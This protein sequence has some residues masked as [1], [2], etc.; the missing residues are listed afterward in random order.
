MIW[1]KPKQPA[2]PQ[3]D[4]T[5][6]PKK[7]GAAAFA[8]KNW[9]WLVPV[10]IVVLA[11]GWWLLKPKNTKPANVDTSY[12]EAMPETRDVSNTLSGTGTL[13]PANTYSVKSLVAGKVLTGS[14]EEGDIVEEGTVLYTVD[15]SDATTKVEQAAITL[16]QAQRSYDKTADRQYVRAEVAGVVSS[17]KVNKGDEVKGRP[18]R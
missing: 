12:T 5:A 9:K 11:G 15:S 6:A 8:K 3:Q 18:P 7:G 2:D 1:N 17:L 4:A 16:Q 10:A 14:F 13:K